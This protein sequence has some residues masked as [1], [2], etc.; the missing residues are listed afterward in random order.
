MRRDRRRHLADVL[1]GLVDRRSVLAAEDV[2]KLVL[3]AEQLF[4]HFR[5][6]VEQALQA[7]GPRRDQRSGRLV[8]VGEARGLGGAAADLDIGAAGQ[9]LRGQRRDRVLA[10]DRAGIERDDNGDVARI[11]L[12]DGDVGNFTD[13]DAVVAHGGILGQAGHRAGEAHMKIRDL[14]VELAADD[15][16]QDACR[17]QQQ[18]HHERAHSDV[19]G[20]SFHLP[21]C[22][23]LS[24]LC[25][26]AVER[27]AA[28]RPVEVRL[29]PR[30]RIAH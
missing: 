30:V 3:D 22:P 25:D 27:G 20:A 2:M 10:D 5:R 14:D 6:L 12:V 29:Q 23:P 7:P 1:D 8:L 15:P 21:C 16:Q 17:A 18:N 9:A 11:I 28:T 26:F 24:R 4:H 13:R 19:I